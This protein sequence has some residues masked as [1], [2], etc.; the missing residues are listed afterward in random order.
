MRW[1]IIL[2]LFSACAVAQKDAEPKLSESYAKAAIKTVIAVRNVSLVSDSLSSDELPDRQRV[3]NTL[4]DAEVEAESQ[5]ENESLKQLKHFVGAHYMHIVSYQTKLTLLGLR[6]KIQVS[7]SDQAYDHSGLT[8][9]DKCV[10]AWKDTLRV[11]DPKTPTACEDAIKFSS[12]E[13]EQ[14]A[15]K[16]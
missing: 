8:Q 10:D 6:G 11:R 14:H 7:D 15:P 1:T 16:R 5:S 12:P 2:L 9:D 4:A 3:N 13:D